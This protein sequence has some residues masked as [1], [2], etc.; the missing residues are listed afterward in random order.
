[1]FPATLY[2]ANVVLCNL[3]FSYVPMVDLGPLGMLSPVAALVGFT[4]VFRD[5]AQRAVGHWVLACM[6]VACLIS[7]YMADPF[8]AIASALAFGV[9]EITDYALYTWTKRPFYKRVLISSLVSTPVD[10]VVFL[11]WIDALSPPTVVL[12][13]ATKLLAAVIVY[14]HGSARE[15][16][17]ELQR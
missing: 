2:I 8:V 10:T 3:L 12:M 16:V 14:I 13:I 17:A 1:M 7:F 4:F 6:A 9:S 11:W 15:S 5:Y